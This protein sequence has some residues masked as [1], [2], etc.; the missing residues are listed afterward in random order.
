M[1]YDK[2]LSR[3]DFL[4]S[5]LEGELKRDKITRTIYSTDA[6]VY[7]EVP[8]AVAWPKNESDIRKILTF[9]SAEKNQCNTESCRD[10]PCRTGGQCG[11]N[12]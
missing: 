12:S 2:L 7:R 4:G 8:L 11:N 6:S 10:I 3:L 1:E 5:S 9:A